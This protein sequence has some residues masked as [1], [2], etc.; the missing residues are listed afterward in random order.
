MHWGRTVLAFKLMLIS[1]VLSANELSDRSLAQAGTISALVGEAE[2]LGLPEISSAQVYTAR[3]LPEKPGLLGLPEIS[4]PQAG[5]GRGPVADATS[6]SPARPAIKSDRTGEQRNRLAI[7]MD[8]RFYDWKNDNDSSNKGYQSFTPLTITYHMGNFNLGYRQ[9]YIVSKNE[10]PGSEGKVSTF[11]DAAFSAAY[12]FRDWRAPVQFALDYNAPVG[13]ASLSSRENN[14]LLVDS[15]LTR[16]SQ[17]G[18]GHNVTPGI[19]ITYA[20][21]NHN[22]GTGI[23][24][25]W[26]GEFDPNSE[27]DNDKIDPGNELNLSAQWQYQQPRWTMIGGITYTEFGRT[28]REDVDF[29]QKGDRYSY[30]LTGIF[31]FPWLGG[32]GSQIQASAYYT[33]QKPDR[34]FSG[35]RGELERE[36]FN[37]NGDTLHLS[38]AWN[39]LFAQRHSVRLAGDFLEADENEYAEN[40]INF[41]AG[42]ERYGYG[43][44]YRYAFTPHSAFSL[45]T[46]RYRVVNK[47]ELASVR[48]TYYSGLNMS[49]SLS[50]QF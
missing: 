28:Q 11:S 49:A 46:R 30:N 25:T 50:H 4:S 16:L 42:R 2:L 35:A 18:E 34:N 15:Y 8:T 17:F 39:K 33:T 12:T 1:S 26:K 37:V 5:T 24:Y 19:N 47:S 14:V 10:T 41:N 23:G 45:T 6:F 27:R 40:S 3:A 20:L 44:M 7:S 36:A 29:F 9:A 43:A 31:A 38:L 22:I 48:D 32:Q 13:K 21:G